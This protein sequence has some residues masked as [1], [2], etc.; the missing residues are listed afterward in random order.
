MRK[1]LATYLFILLATQT[2]WAAT[3]TTPA[4]LPAYYSTLD[5]KS[6]SAL[7][8]AISERAA[9]NAT[10]LTYD[11]LWTAFATTDVYPT[12][13]ANAGKIWD[14]YSNYAFS[15]QTKGANYS[16]EG[17]CYNREHS[18]P[19]SWFGG[20]DNYES[21]N[22]GC[23]LGHLVPTDGYVNG[24]RSNYAFGEVQTPT[25]TSGNGSLLGTSVATL[26]TTATTLSGTS[27]T[28]TSPKVFEPVDE[29]KGDFARIYMYMRARYNDLNLA[30]ADG[31]I[32]HFTTTTTASAEA[33]YGLTDYSVILLMQWHRQDPVSQKEIDRNNGLQQVQ[34]NRNPFVD[35]PYLAEYLWGEHAGETVDIDV[36]V[37]SFAAEFTPG[38]SDGSPSSG[39]TGETGSEQYINY[40]TECSA[41]TWTITFTDKMHG[42]AVESKTVSDG[43][44][45]TFP[46]VDDKTRVSK[47]DQTGDCQTDHY[48]FVGW[49]PSTHTATPIT[50]DDVKTAG[51]TSPTVTAD[52]TYYAVWAKE[53]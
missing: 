18:L 53:E 5:N 36:L 19:K 22:Q 30:Q 50:D 49:L 41:A 31:G 1:H 29:Y 24:M 38:I 27:V 12:G 8:V 9:Y 11:G 20:S 52:A 34:G 33:K 44:T 13:H 16:K 46:S 51:T 21:T 40:V 14:M 6:G 2:L 17:V 48:H 42:T 23:D 4:N 3:V 39:S 37:G 43:G 28:T 15:V 45:F 10:K 47:E 32:V 25:Y 7:F 26:T 35:Y